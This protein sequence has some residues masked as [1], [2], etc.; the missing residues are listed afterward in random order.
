MT[1]FEAPARRQR[2]RGP[3][4]HKSHG[5]EDCILI[6]AWGC[7]ETLMSKC[8]RNNKERRVCP[9]TNHFF[10]HFLDSQD[11]AGDVLGLSHNTSRRPHEEK[12]DSLTLSPV[13]SQ[14]EHIQ[15]FVV[16]KLWDCML[17]ALFPPFIQAFLISADYKR[18]KLF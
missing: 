4:T 3:V 10:Q 16:K 9:L 15:S 6:D 14:P 12:T 8:S 13:Y 5:W 7:S 1:S 18:N 2:H 11:N 17:P